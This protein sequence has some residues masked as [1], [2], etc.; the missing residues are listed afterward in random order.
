VDGFININKPAGL[1]SFAVVKQLR[2]L[3]RGS[4]LGHLGTL[5]P[6]AT[7]V[8]PVAIGN[9]TRVIEYIKDQSKVYRACMTLGGFSDTQDAWGKITFTNSRD[10]KLETL[11]ELLARYTGVVSQVPPMFSAVHHN[12]ERLYELARR[13]IVVDREVRQVQIDHI[14]LLSV[15][16]DGELDLP[17]VE[18]EVAC[19]KGTY[20]RTLCHDIGRE[21][22]SGAYL[23]ALVRTRAGVFT[24]D[25]ASTLDEV[26]G[27][28]A[29]LENII[30]GIDFPLAE[31]NRITVGPEIAA[32]IEN[33]LGFPLETENQSGLIRIYDLQTRLIAIGAVRDH[34]DGL[35]LQPVKVFKI[36]N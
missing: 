1:T 8:L 19:S 32:R 11:P 18:M 3:M 31:M 9:A 14:N 28:Q 30:K 25:D 34:N 5:D 10:Y 36:Q 2:R 29:N 35:F 23:S 7:G 17:V 21:L 22:G 27:N 26:L 12:G 16:S 15:H 33:G 4:K 20:I 24:L 13:G 6:M